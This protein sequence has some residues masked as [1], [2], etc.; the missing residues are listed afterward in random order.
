[1]LGR[2]R[3][4]SS[5]LVLAL[6]AATTAGPGTQAP[7]IGTPLVHELSAAGP[8]SE[9]IRSPAAAAAAWCGTAT[10]TD[11]VPNLVAGHPVHWI[12]AT[13]SDAP[14]RFATYASLMQADAETI[15]AWWRREDPTRTPR[16]DLAQ[17]TC[18]A[19]LDITSL[20]LP[21][22]GTELSG[23]SG[24]ATIFDLVKASGFNSSLTKYL[25]YYDG[26]TSQSTL[27]GRARDE[28]S[29]I[30]LA[31]V[32]VEACAPVAKAQTAAHELLHTLGAVAVGAPNR[33]AA[34]GHVCDNASDL[35]FP[36]AQAGG[37]EQ[38]LLDPGRD[39]YYGHS[40]GVPDIQDGPWLVHLD[41]QVEL[42]VDVT[43]PG[44]VTADRP[45]L[46]CA[47]SCT[48]TWNAGTQL[49]LAATPAEGAKLVRWS[50]ECDGTFPCV[51]TT[52]SGQ[53]VRALFGP[54]VFRLSVVVA[55]RGTVRSAPRGIACSRPRCSA[56]LPS[57]VPVRLT[58]TPAKGWRFRS[59]TGSC[60][61]RKRTCTVPMTK[62]TSARAVFARV[63]ARTR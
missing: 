24:F 18:G 29:G 51:L 10:A 3:R 8:G 48:T 52:A 7:P 63:P 15:D 40:R 34:G 17:L 16:N 33:C 44:R 23:S 37:I 54:S 56:S 43:G 57:Y 50:G 6:L 61:G 35:M 32:Y 2:V 20:R 21:R 22:S 30:G 25:V 19:Q 31:V 12:Y 55:G 9:G 26:P 28:I 42:R 1:M 5:A 39:D 27:C 60:R 38:M 36:S 4:V 53:S 62:Q 13:P 11:R 45:G 58:A 14:D 49:R 41:R 47:Q 59:W 46:D